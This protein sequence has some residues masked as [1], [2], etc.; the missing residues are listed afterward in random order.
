MND[1]K[2][3]YAKALYDLA[4][5]TNQLESYL[6]QIE[7]FEQLCDESFLS[8]LQ[9][10]SIAV[11]DKKEL[12]QTAFQHYHDYVRNFLNV[13]I[14]RKMS[15]SLPEIITAFK[16]LAFEQLNIGNLSIYSAKEIN[17]KHLDLILSGLQDRKYR[18]KQIIDPK[19][20]AGY[21]L[22][23]DDKQV[24]DASLL[25][26]LNQLKDELIKEGN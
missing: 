24:I 18:V 10:T 5:E 3:G 26:R 6:E 16:K 14:D 11:K 2:S 9:S 7:Q 25:K 23:I 22:I 12:I 20:L 17:P 13:I 1:V 21:K 8:F 15:A 19:L 4:L